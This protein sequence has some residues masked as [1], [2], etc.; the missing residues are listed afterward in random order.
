[1]RTAAK[2]DRQTGNFDYP[3]PVGI[4]VAEK[5]KGAFSER[6]VVGHILMLYNRFGAS[7]LFI[8]LGF[9]AFELSGGE[10]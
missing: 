4:F 3:Y 5:G 2:L 9:D 10:F 7:D 1:M 8:D 6:F